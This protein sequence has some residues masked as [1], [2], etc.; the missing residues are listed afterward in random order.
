[1]GLSFFRARCHL[2]RPH[3]GGVDHEPVQA[4]RVLYLGQY[5]QPYAGLAPAAKTGVWG[6]LVTLDSLGR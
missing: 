4:R 1:M 2:V 3:G 6:G 5:P